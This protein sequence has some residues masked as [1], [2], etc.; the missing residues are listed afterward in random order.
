MPNHLLGKK[1]LLLKLSFRSVRELLVVRKEIL[2]VVKRNAKRD[3]PMD[4][5]GSTVK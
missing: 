1:R 5:F 4:T 3:D 2:A